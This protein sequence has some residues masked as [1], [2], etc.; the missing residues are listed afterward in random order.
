M[1]TDL[2]DALN[3]ARSTAPPSSLDLARLE[4][5]RVRRTTRRKAGG[6][7]VGMTLL[8][9]IAAVAVAVTRPSAQGEEA[10]AAGLPLDGRIWYREEFL[11][12]PTAD[13]RDPDDQCSLRFRGTRW[14]GGDWSARTEGGS[15]P[16]IDGT[17]QIVPDCRQGP[18]G[19]VPLEGEFEDA[20]F[21]SGAYPHD[22]PP[23]EGLP[24]DPDEL[25]DHL[26]AASA[27]GGSSPAPAISPG[28]GQALETGGLVDV[29]SNSVFLAPPDLQPGF[30]HFARQIPGMEVIDDT[31][32]P[33]GRPATA[34]HI[35][36]ESID[37]TWYF[38]PQHLQ[39][40]AFVARATDD[41]TEGQTPYRLRLVIGGGIVDGIG[42]VPQGREVLVPPPLHD[43]KLGDVSVP[44]AED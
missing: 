9:A 13:P 31:V 27:P 43:P 25:T 24:T 17:G 3:R 4:R 8:L 36:T 26:L 34:L 14:I 44:L 12:I 35:V 6:L 40:M 37:S 19:Y 42:D 11:L 15:L 38:E 41:A 20:T 18:S 39:V 22:D 1:T 16:K 10:V 33:T 29:F 5:L 28:P 23:M 21:E 2:H 30:Y 32:D 7:V